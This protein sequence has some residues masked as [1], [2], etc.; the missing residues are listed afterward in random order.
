MNFCLSLSLFHLKS[1]INTVIPNVPSTTQTIHC[2]HYNL[3]HF[4]LWPMQRRCIYI[5]II[6][7][8]FSVLSLNRGRHSER[9][10]STRNL[11]EEKPWCMVNGGL[12]AFECSSLQRKPRNTN[13]ALFELCVGKR[14]HLLC[15]LFLYR[16]KENNGSFCL[17]CI[18][19]E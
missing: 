8:T 6:Q 17:A 10:S 7:L 12:C 13:T 1:L 3:L 9:P 4:S 16:Q 14:H 15:T 11:L 2:S 5:C 19:Y 18:V